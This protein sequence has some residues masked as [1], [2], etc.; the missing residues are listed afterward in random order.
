[1]TQN[2]DTE[3]ALE[4]KPWRDDLTEE[5]L[6][7]EE[8]ITCNRW[9]K[10]LSDFVRLIEES[11]AFWCMDMALKYLDIRVDTR[12]GAFIITNETIDGR[13][14]PERVLKAI[15]KWRK[16]TGLAGMNTRAETPKEPVDVECLKKD[17]AHNELS[18]KESERWVLLAGL[19]QG[20]VQ[21]WN[22]CIDHLKQQGY[23]QQ[24]NQWQ[25]IETA[26]KDGARIL[27]ADN[28]SVEQGYFCTETDKFYLSGTN[29]TDF[30]DG[31]VDWATHWKLLD[32]PP[33]DIECNEML[34]DSKENED[35]SI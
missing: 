28:L 14:L 32:E 3:G 24:P 29:H 2:D 35:E 19:E 6:E 9:Y 4:L 30:V 11:G 31:V 33:K 21:G 26:P 22:D 13:I 12:D 34:Q 25:P 10:N 17:N 7:D 5:W 16:E 1:M 8:A 27:L 23:L 20:R 15:N 18:I